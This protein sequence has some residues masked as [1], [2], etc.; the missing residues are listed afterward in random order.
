M[1]IFSDVKKTVK[2]IF[3]ADDDMVFEDE[4][5]F[6]VETKNPFLKKMS[7]KKSNQAVKPLTTAFDPDNHG[8][9]MAKTNQNNNRRSNGK[10]QIYV[11]KTFDEAFAIVRDV[12]AGFTAMVNV[13]TATPQI[14]QRL[15]DVVSGAIYALDGDCKKM[16]EKQYIFSL[17]AETIGAYDYLPVNGD[18][19]QNQTQQGFNF[20]APSFDYNM[21]QNPMPNSQNSFPAQNYQNS[22]N[23]NNFNQNNFN[24]NVQNQ[25]IE[26]T[27][28]DM[29]SFYVP[30]KSQF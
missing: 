3:S 10:I 19:T 24:Q 7:D 5:E 4:N 1:S 16:G 13:E 28:M 6:E 22:F 11:P 9:V 27:A 14:A 12:K 23:Q 17:S 26:R 15:V 25:N 20:M 8:F 30:P 29:Q 21:Q 2:N 18:Q